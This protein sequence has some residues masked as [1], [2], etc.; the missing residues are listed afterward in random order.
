[1]WFVLPKRQ[2]EKMQFTDLE[3]AEIVIPT[4]GNTGNV[5][6]AT[7][8]ALWILKQVGIEKV[9]R[10]DELPENIDPN[11]F[12]LGFKKNENILLE[13]RT[14]K[15]GNIASVYGTAGMLWKKYGKEI[16][17]KNNT[18]KEYIIC[19]KIDEKI[20]QT[21]DF[22]EYHYQG[23]IF[24]IWDDLNTHNLTKDIIDEWKCEV[25]DDAERLKRSVIE[26]AVAYFDDLILRFTINLEGKI[27]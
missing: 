23:E 24:D 25:G 15:N 13:K 27:F 16:C 11:I 10:L 7:I 6:P 14:A 4:G 19:D 20:I 18:R 1:M 5:S 21:I 17:V 3:N 22:N 12:V 8:V 26:D 9:A 2:E